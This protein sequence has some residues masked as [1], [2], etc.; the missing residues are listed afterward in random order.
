MALAE[1][2][3]NNGANEARASG[4]NL[5]LIDAVVPFGGREDALA[6]LETEVF[7]YQ[8]FRSLQPALGGGPGVV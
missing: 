7:S 5:W 1:E 3:Q 8:P 6:A 4:N 2:P